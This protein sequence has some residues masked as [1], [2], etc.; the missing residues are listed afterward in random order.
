MSETKI[1]VLEFLRYNNIKYLW[2]SSKIERGEESIK[3]MK[4]HSQKSGYRKCVQNI[5]VQAGESRKINH[6]IRTY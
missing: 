2:Q 6:K 1:S 3:S 5:C 4:L